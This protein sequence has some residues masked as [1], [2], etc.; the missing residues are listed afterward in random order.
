MINDVGYVFGMLEELIQLGDVLPGFAQVEGAEILVEGLVLQILRGLTIY[1]VNIEVE[2]F[3][4][5][6]RRLRI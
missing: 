3:G 4:H 2:G 1:V 5:I 6:F